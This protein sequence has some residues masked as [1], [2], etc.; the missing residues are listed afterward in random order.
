MAQRGLCRNQKDMDGCAGGWV[1]GFS[2]AWTPASDGA[3]EANWQ[4]IAQDG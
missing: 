2:K 1:V 3:E 4:P